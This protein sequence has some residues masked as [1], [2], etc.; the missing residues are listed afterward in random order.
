MAQR[1]KDSR[2]LGFATPS[3][4]GLQRQAV[5]V[6]FP[7]RVA[8]LVV[9]PHPIISTKRLLL[10]GWACSIVRMKTSSTRNAPPEIRSAATIGSR[11]QPGNAFAKRR[12]QP[13]SARD[14]GWRSGED[15][16]DSGELRGAVG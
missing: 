15:F 7:S 6:S 14:C 12:N 8:K 11:E 13:I 4:R 16:S 10:R 2:P 3:V 1:R 5:C 9:M